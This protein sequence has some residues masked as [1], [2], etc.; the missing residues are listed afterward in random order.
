MLAGEEAALQPLEAIV[1]CG[2][3]GADH[4]LRNGRG[5]GRAQ[6]AQGV[7]HPEHEAAACGL[8][9]DPAPVDVALPEDHHRVGDPADG[10]LRRA[11]RAPCTH[12]CRSWSAGQSTRVR[13]PRNSISTDAELVA[14]AVREGG[15]VLDAQEGVGEAVARP[16][17]TRLERGGRA[18]DRSGGHPD[19]EVL[20]GPETR[21]A[22]AGAHQRGAL[23][24]HGVHAGG[25]QR[26]E[27]GGPAVEQHLV[28]RPIVAVEPGAPVEDR[29]VEVEGLKISVDEGQQATGGRIQSVE[30][31]APPEFA[32]GF[33]GRTVAGKR[34]AQDELRLGR[35]PVVRASRAHHGASPARPRAPRR[36][37]GCVPRW[38]R[39]WAGAGSARRASALRDP[40][41]RHSIHRPPR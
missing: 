36:R 39:R 19:V 7:G 30:V 13:R 18:A 35:G 31:E 22:V 1:G 4:A 9:D 37:R 3:E 14:A 10:R 23:E 25:T 27:R 21:V 32:P 20:H 33:S 29:V 41:W 24:Q 12:A 6:V 16:P 34:G 15:G 11:Q 28:A 5:H 26:V 17:A 38:P 40:R 2:G 8:L